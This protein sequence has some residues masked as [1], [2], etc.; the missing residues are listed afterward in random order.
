M[1]MVKEV[2]G[3]GRKVG[4]GAQHTKIQADLIP[5]IDPQRITAASLVIIG[6]KIIGLF[7]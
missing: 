1:V 7:G 4:I 3:R 2:K 6:L 5:E